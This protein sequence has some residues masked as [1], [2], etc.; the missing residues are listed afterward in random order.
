MHIDSK[1]M[2]RAIKVSKV[3]L[4]WR[5][6]RPQADVNKTATLKRRLCR[7]FMDFVRAQGKNMNCV[8]C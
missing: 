3:P 7:C 5:G 4:K 8:G 2:Q 6:G 1:W